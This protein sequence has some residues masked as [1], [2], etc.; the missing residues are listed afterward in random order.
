[1]KLLFSTLLFSFFLVAKCSLAQTGIL[2]PTVQDSLGKLSSC[3]WKQKTDEDRIAAGNTFFIEFRTALENDK[4]A[5][6]PFD[7]LPGIT[8]T[9]SQDG[10]V[11]IFTWN[12]PVSDGTQKYWGLIQ[13]LIDSSLIVPL[14]FDNGGES[15]ITTGKYTPLHWYGALYY[16]I[17][18]V[19][20]ENT[21]VYTLLGWDGFTSEANR[22]FIDILT[23]NDS[24]NVT[25]GMPVFKTDQGIKS[26][27]VFEFAD[28]A[29]MLLRYDYQAINI[30][31]RKK[32]KKENAWMIVMDRLVPMDTSFKNMRKYYVPS[33]D[34]YDGY[35]FRNGYWTLVE[36]V[37]VANSK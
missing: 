2:K 14:T 17:I 30:Q 32:I 16:K 9:V 37:E 33:G 18:D 31:K 8:R 15:A 4:S 29:N 10:F 24:G 19:E 28:K 34:T 26:R 11:R 6:M 3:I 12:V 21:K 20:I 1:M 25:F 7:S 23:I 13:L 27:I 22:K 5:L 35:I 36:E